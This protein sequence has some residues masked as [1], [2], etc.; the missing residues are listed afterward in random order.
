VES[1]DSKRRR[2][3]GLLAATIVTLVAIAPQLYFCFLCGNQWNGGY[4]QTHGDESVYAAYLNALIDSRP[5]R[6]NPYTGRDDSLAQPVAESYLSVQSFPPLLIASIARVLHVST[7]K[8]FIA[9]TVLT[10]FASALAIFWLLSLTTGDDRIAAVGVLLVL[11]LSSSNLVAEYLLRVGDSNNYLPFLRRYVPA[12]PFPF[13]FGYCAL[14]YRM[15]TAAGKRTAVLNALGAGCLFAVLVFSYV[16]HWTFALVWTFCLAAIWL[17][18]RGDRRQ[19]VGRF[20]LLAVLMLLVL[21][22]YLYL[23]SRLGSTTADVHFLAASHAPDL[24]RLPEIIGLLT[25]AVVALLIR[26]GGLRANE[27]AVILVLTFAVTPFFVFNQQILTGQSLQPFHYEIFIGNYTAVLAAFLT[28]WFGLRNLL[29]NRPQMARALALGFAFAAILSGCAEA[30]LLRRHQLKGN[31]SSD[32]ARP[33]LLRLAE[34]GRN[35]PPGQLDTRSVVYAPNFVVA[36]ALPSTAPQPVLWAQYLF[37]FPD[38]TLAEDKERLTQFLYYRGISFADIDEYHLN[39]LDNERAYYLSSLIK[40]GRF[41]PRLSLDWQPITPE[42]VR[43]A[44][45]YYAAYVATF[46][47]ERAAHPELSY[48]LVDLEEPINL[49]NF[50]RWYERDAGERVGSYTLFRVRLR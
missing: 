15:A 39:S 3:Y 1:S 40:R 34:V 23:T 24:F 10:A 2:R 47:R 12:A 38:V 35:A 9:L 19:V 28:A 16:Y 6:N 46:D 32:A 41:N 31:L 37:L 50:D 27:P 20:L 36:N 42:E 26:R 45:D 18:F 8:A 49:T 22:P 17:I 25:L 44:L 29:R 11:F 14:V 33:A 21:A 13:L 43:G 48:L 7:A 5:R 30:V 4:A